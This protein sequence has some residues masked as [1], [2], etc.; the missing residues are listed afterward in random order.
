MADGRNKTPIE[1][2]LQGAMSARENSFGG[3][4]PTKLSESGN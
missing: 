3:D 2:L 1:L 4:P